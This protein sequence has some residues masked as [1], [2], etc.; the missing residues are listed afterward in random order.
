MRSGSGETTA[1]LK[2]VAKIGLEARDN[3]HAETVNGVGPRES[4]VTMMTGKKKAVCVVV[5]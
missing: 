5:K 4:G 1:Q 2:Q 3:G